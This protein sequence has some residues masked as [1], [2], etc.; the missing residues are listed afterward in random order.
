MYVAAVVVFAACAS[1]NPRSGDKPNDVVASSATQ[2]TPTAAEPSPSG[3]APTSSKPEPTVDFT[4]PNFRGMNLQ[5]AQNEVQKNGIFFSR[6]HDLRGSRNQ[7]LD[8]NWQVCTQTPA[9][10]SHIKGKAADFEGAIDFGVVK[11][12]E[13]C[14]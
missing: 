9:A 11:L 14:P 13:T 2:P 5:D 12:T 7:V 8:S 4:M 10:G 1:A 6:S 3:P